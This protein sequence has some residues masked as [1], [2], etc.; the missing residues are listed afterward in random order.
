MYIIHIEHEAP[1]FELWKKAFDADPIDRRSSGV[2]RYLL[3][4]STSDQKYL[5]IDLAFENLTDAENAL[6]KL[7]AVWGQVEGKIITGPQAR[8]FEIMETGK[9]E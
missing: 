7:K 5:A 2:K 3:Y 4:R 1:S 6:K 8:I 9:I